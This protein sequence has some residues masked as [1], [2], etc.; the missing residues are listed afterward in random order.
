[1]KQPNNLRYT[2]QAGRY[3]GIGETPK[4]LSAAYRAMMKDI[5]APP[6]AIVHFAGKIYGHIPDIRGVIYPGTIWKPGDV[7][8]Y[9]PANDK[10]EDDAA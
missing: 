7:A 3:S 1:M 9:D 4:H 2:F 10:Q 8:L 6:K 5:G